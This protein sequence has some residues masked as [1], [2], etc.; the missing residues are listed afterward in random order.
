VKRIGVISDTHLRE[1]DPDLGPGLTRVWGQ[2]DMILH[3]GD[4]VNMSVLDVLEAPEV[5]AVAGNMDDYLVTQSLPTKLTIQVEGKSIGLIHG[6]GPPMGLAGRVMKEFE[7]VDAI[8]F[9]HSH[10]P[11]NTVKNGVLLFNPGSYGR[12][13][14]GSGTV[15]VLTVAKGIKGEIIKL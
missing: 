1:P 3:A 13:F 4:L 7:E 15:G 11:T 14:M 10:R 12:G 2:V 8:V 9:G 5:L 6:W